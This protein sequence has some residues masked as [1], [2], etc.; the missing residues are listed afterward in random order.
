MYTCFAKV[1]AR[2][3]VLHSYLADVAAAMLRGHL[4]NMNVV[5]PYQSG[6]E[7]LRNSEINGEN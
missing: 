7:Y 3:Y 2:R 5:S 1:S 6:H 4:T